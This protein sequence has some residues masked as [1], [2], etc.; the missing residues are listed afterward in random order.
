MIQA[1][2]DKIVVESMRVEKTKGGIIMPDSGSDP[3]G[4]GKVLSVGGDVPNKSLQ[5]RILV[6]HPRAGMDTLMDESLLKVLKYE[7]VYGILEDKDIEASLA[8]IVIG[9]KAEVAKKS[10]GGVVIVPQ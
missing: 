6:Y 1:V 2:S 7:E 3:I 4:Y 9:K 5:G 10:G 8:P